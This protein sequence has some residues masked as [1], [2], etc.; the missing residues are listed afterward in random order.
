MAE[1][2][3]RLFPK[4]VTSNVPLLTLTGTESLHVEQHRGLIAYQ[5]EEI[6]LRTT[7]GLLHIA[8]EDLRF[9]SYASSEAMICGRISSVTFDGSGVRG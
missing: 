5:P 7:C 3:D 9:S 1:R 8:G 4:E 2:L 6:T